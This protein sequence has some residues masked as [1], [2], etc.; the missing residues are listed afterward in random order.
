MSYENLKTYQKKVVR[1]LENSY[2]KNRLVHTYLFVGNKG[3]LK[4][5]AAYYLA[6]L[7]LCQE[8]GACEGCEICNSFVEKP[9]PY[10]FF[11]TPDGESIKKDQILQLEHEFSMTST[12]KRIFIIE[13]IDK[14]ST[15]SANSLLK[16]LEDAWEGCYGILLTENINLVLPTIISRSQVVKFLPLDRKNIDTELRRQGVDPHIA[17]TVSLLTNDIEEAAA[18]AADP[19]VLQ[20]LELVKTIGMSFEDDEQDPILILSTQGR[21]LLNQG[22]KTNYQYFIDSLIA[23]QNDKIKYILHS[24]KALVYTDLLSSGIIRISLT[25]QLKILEI[26]MEIKAKMRYNINIELALMN[27]LVEIMRCING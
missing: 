19:L 26:M 5:E 8:G 20:T 9:N 1:L 17:T 4:K 18:L 25:K 11:I 27:M 22:S 10:I 24:E 21:F 23:L 15:A 12:N 3:S 16:F 2:E 6:S 7:I 14:A 13:H